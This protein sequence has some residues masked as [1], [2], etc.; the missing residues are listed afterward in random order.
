MELSLDQL[1]A[2]IDAA[3]PGHLDRLRAAAATAGRLRGLADAL[4][5]RYVQAARAEG[6][7]WTDIGTTLGVTKQA[8]HERFVAAPLSWPTNFTEPARQV[9]ARAVGEARGFG[10]R[11]LGTEHLLL[12]LAAEPGLAS[13]ALT[14]LALTE[15]EVRAAIGRRVGTGRAAG[16]LGV[17]PETKRVFELALKDAK[18]F[19][20][21]RCADHE[22]VLLAVGRGGGIGGEILAASGIDDAALRGALAALLEREAPAIAARLRARRKRDLR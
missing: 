20:G 14:D 6:C 10:H 12:A 16:A 9:V 18:R 13:A 22:H 8:A 19:S 17:R 21:Q 3:G 4:L 7:S 11:Y 2:P 15:S 5:D 1:A